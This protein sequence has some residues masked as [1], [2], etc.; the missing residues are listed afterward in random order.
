MHI[1]SI[2]AIARKDAMDILLN[3]ATLGLLLTPIVL[4]I[5]FF[6]VSKLVS[7]HTTEALIY[8]PGRS[9]IEQVVKSAYPN[10]GITYAHAPE[11]VSAAFGPNG[12][13]KDATY[14]LGLIVP[15]KFEASIHAGG[16]PKLGVYVDGGQISN[17]ERN[18]L[19]SAFSDYARN[20]ANPQLPISFN[21]ATINPPAPSNT[22][23]DFSKLYAV[24]M[25]LASLFI[26]SSLVP[27]LLAEEKE[28]K[29]LRM[30]MVSPAS[31]GDVV[32]AK[33]I[34]GL[35]YQLLLTLVAL[36]IQGGFIGQVPL[37]VLFAFLGALFSIAVGLLIGCFFSTTTATGTVSGMISF[38]Y[39]LPMFF[40]GVFT[41]IIPNNPFFQLIKVLPTY[42][43]ASGVADAVSNQSTINGVAL[44]VSITLGVVLLLF[45]IAVWTLRRQATVSASI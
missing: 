21:V 3:K 6:G 35:V 31:F 13:H 41:Q 36:T 44:N 26:G 5:L 15:D 2:L 14:A 9:T 38:L 28:K 22:F 27:G 19:I 42:Y 23:T 25:V 32:A 45:I 37:V 18:L 24:A 17:V 40:V 30:L 34:V 11:D 12:T 7:S 43:I 16:H 29:T 33:L 1:R 4:A 20:I 8:D 39:I 10:I